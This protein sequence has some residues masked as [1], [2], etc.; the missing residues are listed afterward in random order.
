MLHPQAR[1]A[2]EAAAGELPKLTARLTTLATRTEK[3]IESYG[4]NSRLINGALSTLRDVSEAA[5][6]LRSLARTIQRNPN[7]L[8]IGR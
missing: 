4:D 2:V 5:D 3:V 6:A 1:R 7:S 8:I